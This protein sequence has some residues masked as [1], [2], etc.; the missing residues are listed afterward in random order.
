MKISLLVSDFAENCLGR[1]YILA[2][3]LEST[4]EVEVIGPLF[5]EK[6]WFPCNTNEFV[7]KPVRCVPTFPHFFK[8]MGKILHLITG[9]IIY[10]SKPWF[11]SFGIGILGKLQ[12]KKPLILD[13][14]DWELGWY[15]PYRF[16][17]MVSLTLRTIF[18]VN[19]F[20][21]TCFLEKMTFLTD[22]VTTASKFLQDRF[23]GVYIPH[24]RDTQVLDPHKY[25]GDKLKREWDLKGKKIIMFLGSAKPHKGIGDILQALKLLHRDDVKLVIIGS[26]N[27]RFAKEEI[28]RESISSLVIKGMISFCR[29]PEYLACSDLV[30]IPQ[31]NVPS[32]FA[33]VPAKLFDAM[34]M[35]K[36]IVSTRISDMPEILEDCG[37]IVDPDNPRDL[38]EKIDYILTNPVE[39]KEIGEK[40]RERC[41]REYS[42]EVVG[43]RLISY[44]QKA[45][46]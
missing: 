39:A 29:V 8:S 7:Y 14:D 21:N 18:D 35:A 46:Q 19:G 13:I 10:A 41:I 20:L 3:M 24:A 11:T 28:P 44:I 43:Q 6:I 27:S 1:A 34:A 42:L 4:F 33:Q 25:N 2:K 36:P 30:V 31:N 16:R 12:R 5:G 32:N 26:T 23:G 38:A 45:S 17:K 9:D 37:F 15:L 40:A 22:G